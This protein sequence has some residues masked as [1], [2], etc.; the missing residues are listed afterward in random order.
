MPTFTIIIPTYNSANTLEAALKSVLEQSFTNFE[1][2]IMDGSSTD[3]TLKIAQSFSDERIRIYSEP[4]EGV[5][6]AMNKGIDRAE[7]DWLYF[8]GSDDTLYDE[9]V[10]FNVSIQMDEC[11]FLYGNAYFVYSKA[12]WDGE[13][14]R[15]KLLFERNICHQSIFYKRTL[16]DHLGFFNLDFKIYA[17]WDFNM[18]CFSYPKL[19]PKFVNLIIAEFDEKNG[20]SGRVGADDE[21]ISLLPMPYVNEL[22]AIKNS[23]S[24]KYSTFASRLLGLLKKH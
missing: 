19:K 12:I 14:T 11:N 4:D 18:R 10:L 24:Y 20:L 16:F 17:D 15:E 1:I 8:L 13:F 3:N 21:F 5:Y 22:N 2:L 9:N 7:G 6:D 23:R